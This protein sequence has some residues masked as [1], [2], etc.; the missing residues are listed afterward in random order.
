MA[1]QSLVGQGLVP[2]GTSPS[3]SDTPHSVGLLRT[4]DKSDAETSTWQY[5]TI[6]RDKYLYP[7]GTRTRNPSR[8]AAADLC[9]RPRTHQHRHTNYLGSE[10]PVAR[11][12]HYRFMT[13]WN[14]SKCVRCKTLVPP[15][16]MS[17]VLALCTEVMP[18]REGMLTRTS[19]ISVQDPSESSKG[20]MYIGLM[21]S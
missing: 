4:S 6:P 5:T 17:S 11:L 9:L 21:P 18:S 10:L 7:G 16:S 15:A 1:Q 3:H 19:T 13:L 14:N 12:I 2:A 20:R 8:R